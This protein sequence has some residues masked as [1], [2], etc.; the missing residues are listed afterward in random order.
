MVYDLALSNITLGS[1]MTVVVVEAM[2]KMDTMID[3]TVRLRVWVVWAQVVARVAAI[4]S[5]S[6][7]VTKSR[8]S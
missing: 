8:W 6:A 2:E 5:F 7:I 1:F 4:T 3:L